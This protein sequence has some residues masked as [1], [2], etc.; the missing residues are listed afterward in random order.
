M[1]LVLHTCDNPSCINPDHLFAGSVKDNADDMMRKGRGRC[2]VMPGVANAHAKLT[3]DIIRD[4]RLRAASGET[5]R[6]IA[7][8]Y[9]VA[10]A[11]VS[12]IVRRKSWRHVS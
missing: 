6:V 9:G 4:I 8:R 12:A 10:R 1:Q 7:D 2:G 11:T 3:D 5:H